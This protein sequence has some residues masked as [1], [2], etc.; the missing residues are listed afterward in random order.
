MA[1]RV[2]ATLAP[3]RLGTAR[4]RRPAG[5]RRT[6]P[7]ARGGEAHR[8][9]AQ[10]LDRRSA[11]GEPERCPAPARAG[12]S[13]S[14][15]RPGATTHRLSGRPSRQSHPAGRSRPRI[16]YRAGR[17]ASR[18]RPAGVDHASAIGPAVPPVAPGRPESTTHRLSGRPSRQSHPALPI[19]GAEAHRPG[20][21]P[22]IGHTHMRPAAAVASRTAAIGRTRPDIAGACARPVARHPTAGHGHPSAASH[23]PVHR[24]GTTPSSTRVP[25][26]PHPHHH[27]HIRVDNRMHRH[28]HYLIQ[29]LASAYK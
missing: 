20:M 12:L 11:G 7:S 27:V 16:G 19:D 3:L 18:T 1:T 21:P 22:S 14:T 29:S 10:A 17:P 9:G 4:P 5:G 28:V 24:G 25:V 6:A 23:T 15:G 13:A 2:D 26:H 8:A